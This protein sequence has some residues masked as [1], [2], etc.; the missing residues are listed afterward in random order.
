MTY[1]VA[2]L[3]DVESLFSAWKD[4]GA[5]KNR[6]LRRLIGRDK[7]RGGQCSWDGWRVYKGNQGLNGGID[8]ATVKEARAREFCSAER[9]LTRV[10]HGATDTR[11]APG[12]ST[13]RSDGMLE[14]V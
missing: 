11:V 10:V 3:K 4:E 8:R 7:W 5:Y 2:W 14:D 13:G 12:V 6:D 1:T 9:A